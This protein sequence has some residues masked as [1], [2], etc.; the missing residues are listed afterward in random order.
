MFIIG[1]RCN[2]NQNKQEKIIQNKLHIY[3]RSKQKNETS[4]REDK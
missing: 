3:S 2:E 1:H 4:M